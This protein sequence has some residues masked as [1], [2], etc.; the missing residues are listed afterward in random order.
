MAKPDSKYRNAAR[1]LLTSEEVMRLTGASRRT[2]SKVR[3]LGICEPVRFEDRR[4]VFG[5][6]SLIHI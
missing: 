3:D 2:L 4:G 1:P 6:L 5:W